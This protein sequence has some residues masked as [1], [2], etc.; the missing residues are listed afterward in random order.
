MQLKKTIG[1]LFI[2]CI[3]SCSPAHADK[4]SLELRGGFAWDD[5]SNTPDYYSD[6][7]VIGDYGAYLFWSRNNDLKLGCGWHHASNPE[8]PD[9]VLNTDVN[10]WWC[11]V[12]AVVWEKEL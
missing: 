8:E 1:Y 2:A 4:L 6:D 12:N 5:G 7:K 9:H 10:G 3:A 11:G